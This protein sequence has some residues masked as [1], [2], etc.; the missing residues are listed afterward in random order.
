MLLKFLLHLHPKKVAADTLRFRLSFGLGGMCVTLLLVLFFSGITQLVAYT[1]EPATAYDSVSAMYAQGSLSGWIRNIHYWA[2]NLLVIVAV[3]HCCRVYLTGAVTPER[4]WNW[5]MGLGLLFLVL[6]ANFT[7]Y[8]LPWD[9]LAY[10]AVTIFLNMLEYLPLLGPQLTALL[11][12]GDEP[13]RQTLAAF[14][15]LHTGILP[16]CLL[17]ASAYHFYMIRKCGGLVRRRSL[18]K[19]RLVFTAPHLIVREAAV[20]CSL[21]AAVAVFA[22]LVDAPLAE[23]ANPGMTP[24]PAKAAWFFLG[25]QELLIHLHPLYAIGIIPVFMGAALLALPWINGGY[26]EEGQWFDGRGGGTIACWSAA[27]AV[28]VSG[29]LI[30]ID[31][32][33]L[34][35]SRTLAALR[36]SPLPAAILIGWYAILY[37]VLVRWGKIGRARA[38]MAGFIFTV[39]SLCCLT[40]TG[41]CFRG[42]GMQLLSFS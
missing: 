20:G 10:W 13:G 19:D 32:Q 37:A 41:L 6:F 36:Q 18:D 9:Q 31:E 38:I 7:G 42:A 34:N 2:A 30:L 27:A 12:G 14:Y 35:S 8:L 11:Q 22:A 15:A 16:M 23:M 5:Y 40:L 39:V 33:I 29:V 26:L 1:P 17:I 4:A 24:N 3:L 25:F 21:I 28:V